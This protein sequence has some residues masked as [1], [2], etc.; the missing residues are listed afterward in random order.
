MHATV[1][2]TLCHLYFFLNFFPLKILYAINV[3]PQFLK[4]LCNK[5]WIIV[6]ESQTQFLVR[7]GLMNTLLPA[8]SQP[9]QFMQLSVNISDYTCHKMLEVVSEHGARVQFSDCV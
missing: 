6:Y 3:E 7:L 2:N 9:P 4:A 1:S 8:T 5:A